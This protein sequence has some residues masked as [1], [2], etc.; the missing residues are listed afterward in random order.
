MSALEAELPLTTVAHN[1]AT[2]SQA[3]RVPFGYCVADGRMYAPREVPLGKRCGCIC[4]ACKDELIARHEINGHKTPHFSHD[5]GADCANGLETAVHLAAKQLIEQEKLLF[6]TQ[7][8]SYAG[9]GQC[10]W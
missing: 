10:V 8:R 9:K 7:G 6:S 3:V 4:P 1:L 5:S 2:E